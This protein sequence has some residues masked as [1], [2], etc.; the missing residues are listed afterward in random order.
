MAI[1]AGLWEFAFITALMTAG[2]LAANN[3]YK[4][5]LYQSMQSKQMAQG[6]LDDDAEGESPCDEY[7]D[8]E[9]L[10]SHMGTLA[11]VNR[12]HDDTLKSGRESEGGYLEMAKLTRTVRDLLA[13][14]GGSDQRNVSVREDASLSSVGMED[15]NFHG[16][17]V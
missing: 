3:V 7:V 8:L 16:K 14:D 9:N 10:T 12:N 4:K 5:R 13:T 11:A 17:N 15:K 6:D 2:V 1:G